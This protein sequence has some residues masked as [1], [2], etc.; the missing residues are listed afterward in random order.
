MGKETKHIR[1]YADDIKRL[2]GL[3]RLFTKW[4]GEAQSYADIVSKLVNLYWDEESFG[5]ALDKLIKKEG[6]DE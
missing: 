6:K 1:V 5:P 4:E 2:E 3:R